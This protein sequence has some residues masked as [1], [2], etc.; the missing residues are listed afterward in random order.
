MNATTNNIHRQSVAVLHADIPADLTIAEY[1][2]RRAGPT[3]WEKA[4]IGIL[5]AGLVGL[6]AET[7]RARW[8]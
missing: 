6:L 7:A 3:R 1:R 2:S 5:G 8:H 4:R